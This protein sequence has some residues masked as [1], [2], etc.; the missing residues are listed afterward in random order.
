LP[1]VKGTSCV[2]APAGT[3][4]GEVIVIA[5]SLVVSDT[6]LALEDA[7]ASRQSIETRTAAGRHSV[8]ESLPDLQAERL[9]SKP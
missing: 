7:A 1:M 4:T 3:V 6:C 5:G 2:S 9:S 8:I